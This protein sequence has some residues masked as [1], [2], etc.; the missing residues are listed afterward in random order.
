MTRDKYSLESKSI[1]QLSSVISFED[2]LNNYIENVCERYNFKKQEIEE[3][4]KQ[5]NEE[6]INIY[7]VMTMIGKK[8]GAIISGGNVDDEKTAKIILDDFRNGK[9]GNISLEK[10]K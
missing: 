10:V 1:N 6:N 8:R 4:L 3:I 5:D 7:E 2:K 9:L